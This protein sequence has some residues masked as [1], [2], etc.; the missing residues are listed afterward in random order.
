[1]EILPAHGNICPG[2]H[3]V[4]VTDVNGCELSENIIVEEFILNL[5]PPKLLLV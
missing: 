1:M 4:W 3:R 2:S 5:D